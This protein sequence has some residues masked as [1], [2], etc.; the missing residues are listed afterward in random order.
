MSN[1]FEQLAIVKEELRKLE[2]MMYANMLQLPWDKAP[3]WAQWAA[4]DESRQ[5]YWYEDNPIIDERYLAWQISS[6]DHEP[7]D[8]PPCTNWKES[9]RKR[10]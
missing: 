10:P 5:W 1:L 3:E 9:K 6:S 4:M 7:F 2:D 8:F